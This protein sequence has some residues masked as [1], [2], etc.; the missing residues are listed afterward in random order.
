M[1][2]LEVGARVAQQLGGEILVEIGLVEE[3][4]VE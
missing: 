4:L 3:A 1:R 2:E